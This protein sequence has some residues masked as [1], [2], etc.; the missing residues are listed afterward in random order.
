MQPHVRSVFLLVKCTVGS[1][2]LLM[3]FLFSQLGLYVGVVVVLVA[4]A[5]MSTTLQALATLT[6]KTES[7]N[8]GD[9]VR[10]ALG[11]K[12]HM[13][14][15][16]VIV[17]QA[18]FHCTAFLII[19]GDCFAPWV[20]HFQ[21]RDGGNLPNIHGAWRLTVMASGMLV[22]PCTFIRRIQWLGHFTFAG[23]LA[24]AAIVMCLLNLYRTWDHEAPPGGPIH[25]VAPL[26]EN[27]G[28]FPSFSFAFA[29]HLQTPRIYSELRQEDTTTPWLSVVLVAYGICSV[30]YITTGVIGLI[31]YGNNV[32]P[33][34][35]VSLADIPLVQEMCGLQAL[36]GFMLYHFPARESLYE[37][38]HMA[39]N[40]LSNAWSSTLGP[41]DVTSEEAVVSS[42]KS[43]A[44]RDEEG[45]IP[46][47]PGILLAVLI[48]NVSTYIALK[49]QDF[50]ACASMI[51]GTVG[52]MTMFIIPG[53]CLYYQSVE[54]K[55]GRERDAIIFVGIGVTLFLSWFT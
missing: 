37:L 29:C 35:A 39:G 13:F 11:P 45:L 18:V 24:V 14:V 52:S 42:E 2:V 7:Q 40:G 16:S 5:V 38:L 21:A 44:P 19:S 23:A 51:G 12:Q 20:W 43:G 47:V 54:H 41:R 9:V 34:L 49:L 27:A 22:L 50:E 8:Y 6:D 10:R 33:N 36:V 3:P 4:A 31:M 53:T 46:F 25:L 1:S 26:T 15:E 17:L 30:L 32:P 48:T 55:M 28:Y